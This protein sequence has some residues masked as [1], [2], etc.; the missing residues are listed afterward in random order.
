MQA[1]VAVSLSLAVVFAVACFAQ[2]PASEELDADTGVSNELKEAAAE[3]LEGAVAATGEA[4]PVDP[5]S[6]RLIICRPNHYGYGAKKRAMHPAAVCEAMLQ[7]KIGAVSTLSIISRDALHQYLDSYRDFGQ[8][9]TRKR[10]AEA[11]APMYPTHLLYTEYEPQSDK[12]GTL[13]YQVVDVNSMGKLVDGSISIEAG[14][15]GRSSAGVVRAVL[16]G[17]DVPDAQIPG[18]VVDGDPL[19]TNPKTVKMLGEVLVS[20]HGASAAELA[21]L[22]DKSAQL[23]SAGSSTVLPAS[24]AAYLYERA[25]EFDKAL[26]LAGELRENKPDYARLYILEAR[27]ARKAGQLGKAAAAIEQ[28]ADKS[29][30]SEEYYWENGR[31]LETTG[32]LTSAYES[33]RKLLD[34]PGVPLDVHI[35]LAAVCYT[36]G[37]GDE[38]GMHIER[39]ASFA[40]SGGVEGYCE[41]I[42]GLLNTEN[43]PRTNAVRDLVAACSIDTVAP[44]LEV[45]GPD[46]ITITVGDAFEDPGARAVDNI[47]GDI[48]NRVAASGT[49]DPATA[50]EY[51]VRYD[52]FDKAGNTASTTRTVVVQIVRTP[53][54]RVDQ[55]NV[56]PS[57]LANRQKDPPLRR[58]LK[59]ATGVLAVGS[60]AGGVAMNAMTSARL[61]E[62]RESNDADEVSDLHDEVYQY[63]LARNVLYITGGVSA[64]GFAV[65]FAIPRIR[66]KK[67]SQSVAS[68][69]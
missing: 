47:D 36:L 62:Y 35:R 1:R 37:R 30:L 59:I 7:Y 38:C 26:A 29:A 24:I 31:I 61:E 33:Y 67:K 16:G 54:E 64:A 68:V 25:G 53:R 60:I 52:V 15:L 21:R 51:R 66:D 56:D 34:A 39:I 3:Q 43:I 45:L 49:V 28:V 22:A 55:G 12:E 6:V 8:R 46:P 57:L 48:S 27:L 58:A 19:G 63:S 20:E 44:V 41:K 9:I 42:S 4:V 11:L 32:N 17:L 13:H 65:N 5:A 69:E 14:T 23:A 2:D 50:G 18:A 40:A 10:Y